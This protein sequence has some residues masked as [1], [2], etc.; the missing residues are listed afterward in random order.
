MQE[1]FKQKAGVILETV[2]SDR[3]VPSSYDSRASLTR[4]EL[5]ETYKNA[6]K[7]ISHIYDNV[8]P[9][10]FM[11]AAPDFTWYKLMWF[12][13]SSFVS[14]S[15]SY[16]Y[17]HMAFE[18]DD[19]EY[20]LKA[21]EASGRILGK[22]WDVIDLNGPRMK[23]AVDCGLE[24]LEFKLLE[25]HVAARFYHD[26]NHANV[27]IDGRHVNDSA[28]LKNPNSWLK[29]FDS[30]P[31]VLFATAEFI[32]NVGAEH[33]SHGTMEKIGRNLDLACSYI[34]NTYKCPS[35]GPWEQYPQ[36]LH[37]YT[38]ASAFAGL[39]AALEISEATGVP[40]ERGRILDSLYAKDYNGI[41]FFLNKLFVDDGILH[42]FRPEFGTEP[43]KT[44]KADAASYLVFALF[45][46]DGQLFSNEVVEK[47]VKELENNHVFYSYKS[48]KF[49]VD[50]AP[51]RY[52]GDKYF[53]GSGW[54]LAEA[55]E[56]FLSLK[57]GRAEEA[58][59]KLKD[60]NMQVSSSISK[61]GELRLPE[62]KMLDE[63]FLNPVRES[64]SDA[65]GKLP[66]QDL[67]WS[68][69]EYL[70]LASGFLENYYSSKY[71]PMLRNGNK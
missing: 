13:D 67:I 12:R 27:L 69:G 54:L 39:K 11:V 5:A 10:G 7:A 35:A 53:G 57:M 28:E 15:L 16:A 38:V 37:S 18:K 52:E 51:K 66:A 25:N 44:P 50:E 8:E 64:E 60:L 14:S 30:V 41:A 26:G 36:M 49:H 22:L 62:Q 24:S 63:E 40:V 71:T 55:A 68:A 32:R 17:K 46:G 1:T 65:I 42:K 6:L 48:N 29:Q 4:N 9:D 31:L 33:I 19:N 20:A 2:L 70:R 23:H 21:R 47:T 45:N 43:V 59:R 58:T 61:F 3:R 56:G 34:I